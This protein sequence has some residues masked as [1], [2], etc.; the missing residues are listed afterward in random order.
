VPIVTSEKEGAIGVVT[1][2]KPPHNLIDETFL[3]E[4]LAAYRRRRRGW[5]PGHPAAHRRAPLLRGD[6][7]ERHLR[8][9]GQRPQT[10]DNGERRAF[11]AE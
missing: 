6:R 9:G 10:P 3:D 1:V 4:L 7:R 8:E 2:A 11:P 5:L